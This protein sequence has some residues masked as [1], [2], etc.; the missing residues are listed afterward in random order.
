MITYNWRLEALRVAE[1]DV[2]SV[3]KKQDINKKTTLHKVMLLRAALHEESRPF[4]CLRLS[5]SVLLIGWNSEINPRA[6]A[7]GVKAN[8]L[9]KYFNV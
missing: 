3:I 1:N 2:E 7:W 4:C 6:F 9:K 8:V 5:K